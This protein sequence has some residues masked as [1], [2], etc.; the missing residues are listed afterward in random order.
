MNDWFL[1]GDYGAVPTDYSVLLLALLLAFVCGHA[2]AW[3]YMFTHTGLSYSRSYVNSLTVLPVL[4]ALVMM[5]LSNNLVVAFGLMAIFAMVRFRSVLRDTLD[6]T[7]VLA[8]IVIG[9]ACGTAKFT[10]A[11][12]GCLTIL[13]IMLYFWVTGFG[14]RHRYDLILNLHWN[15]P[16]AELPEL[17]QLLRRHARSVLCAS[18]RSSEDLQGVDLSYRLLLRNPARSHELM[19]ELK[20]FAGVT[21]TSSLTAEDES[22]L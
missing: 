1:R 11:I 14:T 2:V 8:T 4:V 17:L 19:A 22:E 6:T 13:A 10:T 15:R 7:Y 5:V 20:T 3:A 12:I 21:R 16:A 9:L 18:Q